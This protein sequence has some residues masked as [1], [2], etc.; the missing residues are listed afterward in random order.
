MKLGNAFSGI[1]I[2]GSPSN[3]IGGFQIGARNLISGNKQSGI[4]I[5][6]TNSSA[7]SVLG[8][9][10][11]TDA[12]GS[13]ALGNLFNGVLLS[14]AP[15]NRVGGELAGAANLISGNGQRG[16]LID[17]AGGNGNQVQGNLIGTDSTGRF[18]LGNAFA[19]VWIET[20]GN[21]IGGSSTSAR[22]VISGNDQS[23]VYIFGMAASNNLVQGNFIGTDLN[24][25]A[26]LANSF[27]GVNVTNAPSNLIGGSVIGAGNLISGNSSRGVYFQG[28]NARLNRVEGNFIGTDIS[29]SV[30]I[31]NSGGVFFFGSPS[32]TVGGTV[33]GAANLISGNNNVAISI[34]DPGAKGEHRPGKFRWNQGG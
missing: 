4:A 2:T 33:T 9:F 15:S 11:G 20:A 1:G 5:D 26:A 7:N 6:G 25:T 34:G 21:L 29:G 30:A 8:N 22:N 18:D 16:I 12:S 3:I 27:G 23:G 32:N 31:P 13:L 28:T 14:S 10:I 19:G 17:D 24:G